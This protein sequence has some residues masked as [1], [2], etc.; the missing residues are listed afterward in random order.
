MPSSSS[1][2]WE[3]H[4]MHAG[5]VRSLSTDQDKKDVL[6]RAIDSG[7]PMIAQQTRNGHVTIHI[8]DDGS[9][10]TSGSG[11]KGNRGTQ[12]FES[13]LRRAHRSVGSD[14]P[15]KTESLKQFQRR[16]ENKKNG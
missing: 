4:V 5:H 3:Q 15:R 9:V 6:M 14:F 7:Y 1:L 16:M 13:E 12:N 8:K 10:V 11:G 2:N